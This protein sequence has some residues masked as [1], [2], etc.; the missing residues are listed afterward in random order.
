M[1]A[2]TLIRLKASTAAEEPVVKVSAVVAATAAAAAL[3][4]AA[5]TIITEANTETGRP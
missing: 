5:N 2:R 3:H 1:A 4:E